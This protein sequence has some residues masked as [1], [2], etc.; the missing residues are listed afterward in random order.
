MSR[1]EWLEL[2]RLKDEIRGRPLAP[3]PSELRHITRYENRSGPP[4]GFAAAMAM[5]AAIIMRG[6]IRRSSDF[7]GPVRRKI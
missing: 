1:A 4:D 6:R 5:M 3:A 7:W 2:K